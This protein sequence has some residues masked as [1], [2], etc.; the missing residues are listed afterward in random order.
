MDSFA[1]KSMKLVKEV[2]ALAAAPD[3]SSDSRAPDQYFQPSQGLSYHFQQGTPSYPNRPVSPYVQPQFPQAT[4]GASNLN[5][6]YQTDPAHS[7][8]YPSRQPQQAYNQWLS[9]SALPSH[10]AS[11]QTTSS[12]PWT[13]DSAFSSPLNKGQ[14]F[15]PPQSAP[16][17]PYISNLTPEQSQQ[18][19]ARPSLAGTHSSPALIPQYQ[20]WPSQASHGCSYPIT[21]SNS[22]VATPSHPQAHAS[23]VSPSTNAHELTQSHLPYPAELPAELPA[24]LPAEIPVPSPP[25]LRASEAASSCHESSFRPQCNLRE[26]APSTASQQA[27]TPAPPVAWV[28]ERVP[29]TPHFDAPSALSPKL[30]DSHRSPDNQCADTVSPSSPGVHSSYSSVYPP[31]QPISNGAG[32]PSSLAMS[33][34]PQVGAA[35]QGSMGATASSRTFDSSSPAQFQAAFTQPSMHLSASSQAQLFQMH[36]MVD[37]LEPSPVASRSTPP[38]PQPQFHESRQINSLNPSTEL[39]GEGSVA[40]SHDLQTAVLSASASR[41][42]WHSSQFP[43]LASQQENVQPYLPAA[44]RITTS[45]PGNGRRSDE[46]PPAAIRVQRHGSAPTAR[47]ILSLD[48]GGVRGLSILTILKH[49]MNKLGRQRGAKLEPWQEFDMIAGTS[50]GGLIAI[51]LGRLRMSVTECIEAYTKLSR[52]IFTPAHHKVNIT[53]RAVGFL[54]AEGKFDSEP[55]EACIKQMIR[56]CQLPETA[57]LKDDDPDAPKV[58]VC[59][60]QGNNGDTVLIR[61]YESQAYDDLYD[62]CKIWEAARATSAASTFF[63]PIKIGNQRYVDG[64]LK[65]N[66]PIE[67]VDEESRGKAAFYLTLEVSINCLTSFSQSSGQARTALSS[68]SEPAALLGKMSPAISSALCRHSQKL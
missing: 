54:K 45:D 15:S 35:W 8:L 58:F 9:T 40:L 55:L 36:S 19:F 30:S 32:Y 57:L 38:T 39:H 1:K 63:D 26:G 68:A 60:V 49:V 2:Y 22:Q 64:A 18:L 17:Q 7:P 33:L 5:A 3:R 52:S 11:L 37:A 29:E 34:T 42:P 44:S 66:N 4:F 67:K 61:S 13:V 56:D 14:P 53:G 31:H 28:H 20:A 10:P 46:G 27:A 43:L 59:A 48:G 25:V 62:I 41:K 65:H 16:P 12:T 24:K 47:K 51:M 50:T 23:P 21:S 6:S